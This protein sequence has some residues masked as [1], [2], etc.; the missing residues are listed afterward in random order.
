[1]VAVLSISVDVRARVA[2]SGP[3]LA[4][5]TKMSAFVPASNI[6]VLGCTLS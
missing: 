3:A 1:M 4:I 6:G 5:E 2:S